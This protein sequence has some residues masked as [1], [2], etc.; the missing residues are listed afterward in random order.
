MAEGAIL[1]WRMG[2]R[3]TAIDRHPVDPSDCHPEPGHANPI[4]RT[5][6]RRAKDLSPAS[7]QSRRRLGRPVIHPIASVDPAVAADAVSPLPRPGLS[8]PRLD[9]TGLQLLAWRS[10]TALPALE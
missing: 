3:G 5:A 9:S 10:V 2:D 6:V 8:L 4:V 1:F 7:R